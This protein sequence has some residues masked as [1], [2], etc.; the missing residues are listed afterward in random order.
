MKTVFNI[1]IFW[2]IRRLI[3][4]LKTIPPTMKNSVYYMPG[5]YSHP[6]SEV[7][8]YTISNARILSLL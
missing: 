4:E 7:G 3:I 6:T 8:Y 2:G 5:V 1:N